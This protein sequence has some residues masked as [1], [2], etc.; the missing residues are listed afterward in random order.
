MNKKHEEGNSDNTEQETTES[1]GG[2]D[3][4]ST[5]EDNNTG[6]EAELEQKVETLTRE[7]NELKDKNL[8]LYAEFDNYR[9]RSSKERIDLV[10]S[11]GQDV[12]ASL[13]PI[14]DDFERANKQL[15]NSTD[16]N[17]VK[18]GILLIQA[19]LKSLLE[20]KGLTPMQSAG[21]T[22]DADLHDAITE[23]PA[24]S[25]DM[26]GKVIEEIEKGY[27]LNDKIIRHAKVIVGK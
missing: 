1:E 3:T 22:F 13:L 6:K 2:Q 20:Q 10:K 16:I 8:R 25:E 17:A 26:K 21:E 24:P 7:V 12:I 27:Y 19:K 5:K 4:E 23:A 15:E 18:E 14:L 11:A 9:K